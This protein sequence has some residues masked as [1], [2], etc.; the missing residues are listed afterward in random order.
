MPIAC[1]RSV[2]PDEQDVDAVEGGD[3][4][5]VLNGQR[6]LDLEDADDR[7]VQARD[8][9]VSDLAQLRAARREGEPA[10]ASGG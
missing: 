4:G 7:G 8:V 3:L 9:G 6:R 2:G 1:D 5:G 10:D